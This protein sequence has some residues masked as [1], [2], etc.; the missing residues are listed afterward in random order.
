M[1][2]LVTNTTVC[3]RLL[4]LSLFQRNRNK[5]CGPVSFEVRSIATDYLEMCLMRKVHC[6]LAGAIASWTCSIGHVSQT[7][8]QESHR[9]ARRYCDMTIRTDLWGWSLACE[10]LLPVAIETRVVSRELRYIRKGR[11]AFTDFFPVSS[12][13]L[14]ARITSQLLLRDVSGM[15]KLR[16]NNARLCASLCCCRDRRQTK[17]NKQKCR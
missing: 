10:E 11:I 13:E 14:V 3:L 5:P 8:K 1:I 15:R 9:I 7:R 2:G 6:K 17:A 4:L 16:V 12:R